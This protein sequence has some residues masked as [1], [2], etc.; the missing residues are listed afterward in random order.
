MNET[1]LMHTLDHL[2]DEEKNHGP[3]GGMAWDEVTWAA[4][5]LTDQYG[6]LDADLQKRWPALFG[7]L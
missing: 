6:W 4:H 7:S 1:M 2:N 5:D 3:I